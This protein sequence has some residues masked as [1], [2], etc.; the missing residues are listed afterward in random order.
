MIPV[1]RKKRGSGSGVGLEGSREAGHDRV[2]EK[3][4]EN[5]IESAKNHDESSFLLCP[6]PV[7]RDF[8]FFLASLS[9]VFYLSAV[10]IYYL[11]R[12]LVKNMIGLDQHV[13]KI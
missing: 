10:Y 3:G 12:P 1:A 11:H 2:S 9:L 4:R 6:F 13:Y 5:M 8:V 7:V